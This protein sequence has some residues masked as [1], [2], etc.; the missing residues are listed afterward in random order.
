MPLRSGRVALVVLLA[1]VACGGGEPPA[2]GRAALHARPGAPAATIVLVHGMGG[3]RDL[4][5]LDYFYGVPALWRARG[6][7]VAV[8]SLT[9][10]DTIEARAAE[11]AAQLDAIP[12]PLVIV[13]HSQG[14][15]DARYAL[16]TLGRAD[17]V[18]ALV[19]IATP[20]HGSPV[21]DAFMGLIPQA[22]DGASDLLE[23]FG[24]SLESTGEMTTPY[25]AQT[26]NPQ[27]PDVPGVAYWSFSGRAAPF[28]LGRGNGWLHAPLLGGWTLMDGLG[29]TNDGAVPERS[30]HWGAFQGT[31][32]GDHLGEVG[33]PLGYTPGFEARAFYSDLLAALADAGF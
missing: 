20:H 24:W 21:A 31:I 4:A 23:T 32:P 22:V 9:S 29:L 3:F 5:G 2:Q 25:L 33:Q 18:R 7:R 28:G 14:G 11:L 16:S 19:T 10:L 1:L 6:A 26:F 17:R 13:A 30:A 8:A 15:L 12:G 27:N